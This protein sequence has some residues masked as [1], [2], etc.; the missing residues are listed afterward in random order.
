LR[1]AGIIALSDG[2]R[3][4]VVSE[5]GF[6]EQGRSVVV[7]KADGP[8]IVVRPAPPAGVGGDELPAP[9][10]SGGIE[11]PADSGEAEASQG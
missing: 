8:R 11:R 3:L 1:P 10:E 9:A 7:A 4:D 5:G 2:R 6:I